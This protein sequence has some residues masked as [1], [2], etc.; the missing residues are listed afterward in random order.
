[1]VIDDHINLMGSNPLVGPNDD[2]FGAAVPGHDRGLFVAAARDCRRRPRN[3]GGRPGPPRRLRGAARPE[4]RDAGRDSLSPHHRRRRRRHVHRARGHRRAAHGHRGAR[5]LVHHQS[6]GRRVADAARSRR[7]DGGG[8]P[9]RRRSSFDCW[10]RSLP[11]SDPLVAAARKARR[12]AVA[13]YS[14]FKVGAALETEDGTVIEG[15]NVENASYG[16]TMCA[17]R[18]AMFSALAQGHRTIPAHRRR[19]R[20]RRADAALWALPAD[21]VGVR[22]RP[23]GHARQP[24]PRD[25]H[26]PDGRPPAAA[27]RRSSAAMST[28]TRLVWIACLLLVMWRWPCCS[29]ECSAAL[30]IRRAPEPRRWLTRCRDV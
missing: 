15:C 27:I 26:P 11:A 23:R 14:K 1:M 5:H 8:A 2:R 13:P 20:H 4:L 29:V 18:V 30:R 6:C 22:R 9:R 24:S 17:E 19:R 7:S 21:P 28:R 3:R 10:R 25:R 16:L 12:R